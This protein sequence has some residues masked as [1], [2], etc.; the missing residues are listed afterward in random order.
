MN[1]QPLKKHIPCKPGKFEMI[2]PAM[3]YTKN[4]HQED[5]DIAKKILMK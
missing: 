5:Q 3:E 1:I 2:N 4:P